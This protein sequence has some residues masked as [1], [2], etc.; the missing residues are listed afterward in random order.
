MPWIWLSSSPWRRGAV[1]G[2]DGGR[3]GGGRKVAD[4]GDW[5][6]GCRGCLGVAEIRVQPRHEAGL[7]GGARHT[8]IWQLRIPL[9]MKGSFARSTISAH[10]SVAECLAI[11][12]DKREQ[13][14]VEDRCGAGIRWAVVRK[15]DWGATF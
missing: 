11:S 9:L 4:C 10:I 5:D 6:I 12:G 14:V 2:G 15:K 13:G 8:C 3:G 7:L 1:F